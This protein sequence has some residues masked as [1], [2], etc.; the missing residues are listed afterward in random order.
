MSVEIIKEQ[1]SILPSKPGVYRML[2]EKGDVLYIGKAK[3]LKKRITS[4][5]MLE[6]LVPRMQRMV[7]S[8]VNLEITT[9][10]TEAEALLL[11]S[12]LIKNLHPR[13]NI[14]LRD[15]KSFPYITITGHEYPRVIK[16]RGEKKKGQ[17]YF[18][19]FASAG[20]VN[21]AISAIQKAFL[22]RPCPDSV[23]ASRSR[24]CL[25]YQIKR[26]SAPC[27][28][29]IEKSDY[30]ELVK[31]A[32]SFLS[33]KSSEAQKQLTGLMEE[34]SRQMDYEK[35]ATYR[36]RIKAF[37][38]IQAKQGINTETVKNADIVAVFGQ[39][40]KFCIQ[41]FFIRGGQ[42]IG[43]KSFFPTQTEGYTEEEIIES[44][45]T[46]FYQENTPPKNIILSHDILSKNTIEKIFGVK[47]I[48]PQKG[49]KRH[50][51]EMA[52]A[53]ARDELERKTR[54]DASEKELIEKLAEIFGIDEEIKRI[55]VYDNSHIF[56]KQA[57]GAMIVATA[58]GFEKKSYRRFNVAAGKKKT[59]GDDYFMLRQV[60]ERRFAK[61]DEDNRPDLILIDGG[62]GHM[63]IAQEVLADLGVDVPFACIAKGPDRNSGREDFY[64]PE[65]PPFKLEK[66]NPLLYYLQRLRDEAHRF[67]IFSHRAKRAKSVTKSALDEIPGIGAKRKKALLNHF[68]SVRG[69]EQ[70]GMEELAK[71]SGISKKVAQKIYDW[72]CR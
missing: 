35:A 4:Y 49:E 16:Y 63:K 24:P 13:Y 12:N 51:A 32:K 29:K 62:A 14:L 70:A 30:N 36:D 40:D 59:G 37:A 26:C 6:K 17:V 38:H 67:A 15:D 3:N 66:N 52:L 68:G 72:L 41:V 11:E 34:A 22:V 39:G 1:L 58:S 57:V 2:G 60:L 42:T 71:V 27:V 44:F 25:E 18:G 23:F 20:D 61:L 55:E 28:G 45:I 10:R 47:I 7:M 9:T 54:E 21:R 56:G 53:N 5:T 50:L 64:I 8:A 33:G 65:K 19:P 69:I 31:Q 43:N 46:R 48:T